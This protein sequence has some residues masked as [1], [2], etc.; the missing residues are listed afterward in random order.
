MSTASNEQQIIEPGILPVFIL[1]PVGTAIS[2]IRDLLARDQTL[3]LFDCNNNLQVI[4]LIQKIGGGIVLTHAKDEVTANRIIALM[5]AIKSNVKNGTVRVVMTTASRDANAVHYFEKQGVSDVMI[6]PVGLKSFEHK[7]RRHQKLLATR[8]NTKKSEEAAAQ[9]AEAKG[10]SEEK[11]KAAQKPSVKVQFGD[12]MKIKSEFWITKNGGARKI[13]GRW[14]IKLTGPAP[15]TGRWTDTESS[16]GDGHSGDR[17]WK[18][19][20][21]DPTKDKFHKEEGYWIFQGHKPEFSIDI[22]SFVGKNPFLGFYVGGNPIGEKVKVDPAT[23]DLVIAKDS[24]AAEELYPAILESLQQVVKSREGEEKEGDSSEA[25]KKDKPEGDSKGSKDWNQKKPSEKEEIGPDGVTVIKADGQKDG[26]AWNNKEGSSGPGATPTELPQFWYALDHFGR[27]GGQWNRVANAPGGQLWAVYLPLEL[28]G[29][30]IPNVRA[31]TNLWHYMGPGIPK[32]SDDATQWGFLGVEPQTTEKFKDLNPIVRDYFLKHQNGE[33]FIELDEKLA[34]TREKQLLSMGD[35]RKSKELSIELEKELA[36]KELE[37]RDDEKPREGK[38]LNY[39]GSAD[40]EGNELNDKRG[41]DPESKGIRDR[42]SKEEQIIEGEPGV[43]YYPL[44]YF[45]ERGGNWENVGAASQGEQWYLYVPQDIE[46]DFT[47]GVRSWRDIWVIE[48]KDAPVVMRDPTGSDSWRFIEVKPQKTPTFTDLVTQ[49]QEYIL[50]R[51]P[52]VSEDSVP[53]VADEKSEL[54]ATQEGE[55]PGGESSWDLG[56]AKDVGKRKKNSVTSAE[57]APELKGPKSEAPLLEEV[58]KIEDLSPAATQA[59]DEIKNQIKEEIPPEIS[60][61]APEVAPDPAAAPQALKSTTP[62]EPTISPVAMAFLVSEIL[63]RKDRGVQW[64]ASRFCEYLSE[65]CGGVGVELWVTNG[66]NWHCA[67]IRGDLTPKYQSVAQQAE[68]IAKL[69]VR[70]R[71]RV[72]SNDVAFTA[73]TTSAGQWLGTLI[74]AGKDAHQI[75]L[76]YLSLIGRV[77]AGICASF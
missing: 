44:L 12:P 30:E 34:N 75:P 70:L 17:V 57:D 14:M 45:D 21:T 49:V 40:E 42:R 74:L 43:F 37:Y 77:A 13:M 50:T 35:E 53:G 72:G 76:E 6:E 69:P 15:N 68:E 66:G 10:A 39:E 59:L 63:S 4:S 32:L 58:P 28:I 47:Q 36:G 67:S 51:F 54:E 27:P 19:T 31:M 9:A 23:G 22:W 64:V 25:S 16:T 11:A 29:G 1:Q 71:A 24:K 46:K 33:L 26:I 41:A 2:S 73:V 7:F 8:V 62:R 48:C 61:S 20:P 5:R 3:K 18:W 56:G 55:H 38:E 65:S 60:Q 52:D